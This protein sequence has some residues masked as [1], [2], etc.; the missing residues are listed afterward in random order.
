MTVAS[1][2]PLGRG[3]RRRPRQSECPRGLGRRLPSVILIE[4]AGVCETV[5]VEYSVSGS[6]GPDRLSVSAGGFTKGWIGGAAAREK[7]GANNLATNDRNNQVPKPIPQRNLNNQNKALAGLGA[8]RARK[9][10]PGGP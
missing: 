7:N 4:T 1:A 2:L 10:S 9:K 6:H 8:D 5:A 3:P